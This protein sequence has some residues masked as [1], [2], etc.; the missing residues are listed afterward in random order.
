MYAFWQ[1]IDLDFEN[2]VNINLKHKNMDIFQ[3]LKIFTFDEWSGLHGLLA[4]RFQ[5][6][7]LRSLY[8][9]GTCN[10][11]WLKMFQNV[12]D[13]LKKSN[14]VWKFNVRTVGWY[15]PNAANITKPP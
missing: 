15:F 6:W 4:A 8:I 14:H 11:P 2:R 10:K 1:P 3:L 12:T 13:A 7:N 9:F 5:L